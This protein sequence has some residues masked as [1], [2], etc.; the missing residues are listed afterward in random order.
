MAIELHLDVELLAPATIFFAQQLKSTLGEALM[1]VLSSFQRVPRFSALVPE[2]CRRR[3]AAARREPRSRA[4]GPCRRA[5]PLR[6]ALL[7]LP[8][9]AALST[10]R[11]SAAAAAQFAA[12][13]PLAVAPPLQT[14]SSPQTTTHRCARAPSTFSP[15]SPSPPGPNLAGKRPPDP[16]LCCLVRQ[17]PPLRRNRNPGA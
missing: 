9:P 4:S 16:P 7:N 8:S 1:L 17:G 15:T 11:R 10:P 12:G 13:R 6:P 2:P 3:Q 14:T 5:P